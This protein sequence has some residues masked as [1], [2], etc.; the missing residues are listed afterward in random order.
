[1][2]GFSPDNNVASSMWSLVLWSFGRSTL[3]EVLLRSFLL[4]SAE[5]CLFELGDVQAGEEGE[6]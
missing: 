1:M 5:Q 4:K 3:I 6:L 2:R